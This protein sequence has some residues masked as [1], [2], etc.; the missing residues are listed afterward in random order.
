MLMIL[1]QYLCS[2][3]IKS[4]LW[5]QYISFKAICWSK[6]RTGRLKRKPYN[7]NKYR[8]GNIIIEI[9]TDVQNTST[10]AFEKCFRKETKIRIQDAKRLFGVSFKRIDAS[11]LIMV[12][13]KMRV[14]IICTIKRRYD[15]GRLYDNK[16]GCKTMGNVPKASADSLTKK[17]NTRCGYCWNKLL[18]SL[19]GK[20]SYLRVLHVY[21]RR[22]ENISPSA[23]KHQKVL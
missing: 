10:F 4:N 1:L 17:K 21:P 12:E 7:R 15:G 9:L 19:Y 13:S 16:R 11:R 8:V 2:R 3:Y 6:Y 14:G 22:S 23:N 5:L 18:D 20:S